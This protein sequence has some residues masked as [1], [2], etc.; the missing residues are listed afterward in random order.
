MGRGFVGAVKT[1]H[2]GFP[3]KY[4]ENVLGPLHAGS[5][6]VLEAI[7]DGEPL[8]AIGYK[9]NRRKVLSF[10]ATKGAG[11]TTDGEPYLQ[12]WADEHGNVITRA[13]PR[14]NIISEYFAVSPRIDNHNQ[15]RQADL[16]L[17][18]EWLTQ[19]CWFRIHT[20]VHGM[21]VVD[22]WKLCRHHLAPQ[23]RLAEAPILDFADELAFALLTNGMRDRDA[24]LR[25]MPRRAALPPARDPDEFTA[26]APQH[27]IC[28]HER[29]STGKQR[30]GR[31]RWCL[32]RRGQESWSIFHCGLCGI[33]VCLPG[34]H[35]RD[36]WDQHLR[37]TPAEL[38]ELQTR[39]V[40]KRA[41][42]EGSAA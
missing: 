11:V 42:L 24:P 9:Y 33:D 37:C 26:A 32:V 19:D 8:L 10:V 25:E 27:T 2:A 38:H 1:A 12:R 17:E 20:T 29:S 18:E 14:P 7:C 36:C 31:C 21:V 30:Q 39:A 3:K 15:S 5:R 23:H 6:I 28:R 41:R 35:G 13:I 4:I 22:A 16:A 40:A 34:L